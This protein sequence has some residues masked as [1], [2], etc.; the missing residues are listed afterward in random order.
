MAKGWICLHRQIQDCLIWLD[1]EP[2]DRR[3]AWIDLLLLANHEDKEILFD[4]KKVTIRRG[5]FLTSV[6]KLSER[7][8]W[9]KDR[10]LRY[11]RLLEKLEMIH[12]ESNARR[13]LLTIIKYENYQNLQDTHK[14]SNKDTYK[15]THKPQTTIKQYNNNNNNIVEQVVNYLNSKCGTNY[16]PTTANTKK[17]ISARLN[18][19]YTF[20]DFTKVIDK[21]VKDWKGTNMEQ[22]LRPDTLFGSK[23]ESYLNQKI[24]DNRT[25]QHFDNENKY[26]FDDLEKRLLG[27][28]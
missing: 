21:K 23:F 19:G 25:D 6:R 28:S 26:D 11:L 10:T 8:G 4:G 7:W 22:Y 13:T 3:S 9:S 24:V 18:D 17:H 12:R 27:E 5:Q 14:D 15:D 2:F 16:K 1:D 20:D